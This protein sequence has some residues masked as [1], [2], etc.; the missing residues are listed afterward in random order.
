MTFK[1][2]DL[3]DWPLFL[4]NPFQTVLILVEALLRDTCNARRAPCI[5]LNMPLRLA[6]VGGTLQFFNEIRKQKLINNFQFCL[7]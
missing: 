1:F 6:A 4:F 2:G 5:L 7:Q 3:L